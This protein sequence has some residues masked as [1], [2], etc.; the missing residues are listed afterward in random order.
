[1]GLSFVRSE[2]QLTNVSREIHFAQYWAASWSGSGPRVTWS[3]YDPQEDLARFGYKLNMKL[4]FKSILLHIVYIPWTMYIHPA[5][6]YS[7]IFIYFWQ[8][9]ISKSTWFL[10]FK[11]FNIAFWMY[12]YKAKTNLGCWGLINRVYW[13]VGLGLRCRMLN[14]P[15]PASSVWALSFCALFARFCVYLCG[16]GS[17]CSATT[18]NK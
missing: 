8:L 12:I 16:L 6:D 11:I 15:A 7:Y 13:R 17:A 2:S 5:D 18:I 10:A 4:G 3:G 14:N 9:K 1:M